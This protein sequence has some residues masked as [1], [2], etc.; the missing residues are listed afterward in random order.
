MA[1]KPAQPPAGCVMTLDDLAGRN[2][3]SITEAAQLCDNADPR[4]IRRMAQRGDIP[5]IKVGVRY[6]IPVAWLREHLDAG[7]T[8]EP[9]AVDLDQL[10][11]R[12]ADRV[13][14][15]VLGAFAALGA[16][17]PDVTGERKPD[18]EH[19]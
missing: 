12:V 17:A 3:A 19:I 9:P 2:F 6:M 18:V 8:P 7:V 5:S 15:R 1:R 10:A 13:A 16:L 4:T 11:D 14:A